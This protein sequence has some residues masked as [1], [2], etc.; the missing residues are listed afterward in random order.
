M[1]PAGSS[2]IPCPPGTFT[3]LLEVKSKALGA[4]INQPIDPS[5]HLLIICFSIYLS[6]NL[7]F[8]PILIFII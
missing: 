2:S 8:G 5:V 1:D 7:S 6:M 4:K 3:V